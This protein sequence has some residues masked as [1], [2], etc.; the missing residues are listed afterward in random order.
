MLLDM[1]GGRNSA[2]YYESYSRQFAFP[3]AKMIWDVGNQ[4]GFSDFFRYEDNGA[5]AEDDHYYI[6]TIAKIPTLE[7][8]RHTTQRQFHAASP[9]H[10]RQHQRHRP[11]DHAGRGPD[12]PQRDLRSAI[13]LLN[14]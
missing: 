12:A 3:Q 1:V 6:N 14:S 9:Y 10:E 2:F 7:H 4:S 5:G 13:Q 8:H 11:Q